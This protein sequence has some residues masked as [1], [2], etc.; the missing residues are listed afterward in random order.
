MLTSQQIKL[1]KAFCSKYELLKNEE[2]FERLSA[3]SFRIDDKVHIL[4]YSRKGIDDYKVE[5]YIASGIYS[6]TRPL[7]DKDGDRL[8][9]AL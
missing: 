4:E 3:Y 1:Y 2:G 7:M 6:S 5:E 8:Y 9:K